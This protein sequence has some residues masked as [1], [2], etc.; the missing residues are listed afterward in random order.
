MLLVSLVENHLVEAL[1]T[2][3][4]EAGW[5]ALVEIAARHAGLPPAGA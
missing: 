4:Q 1:A 2:G 3:L 5:A